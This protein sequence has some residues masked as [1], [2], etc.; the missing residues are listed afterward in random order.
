MGEAPF[1]LSRGKCISW[2]LFKL[3]EFYLHLKS[4]VCH[5][6]SKGSQIRLNGHIDCSW[7]NHKYCLPHSVEMAQWPLTAP[8]YYN[9]FSLPFPHYPRSIDLFFLQEIKLVCFI[10]LFFLTCARSQWPKF[11]IL[12]VLNG[13][14]WNHLCN[15]CCIIYMTYIIYIIIILLDYFNTESSARN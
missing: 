7:F 11:K 5:Q 9:I 4:G 13:V 1:R 12:T 3:L 15:T 14:K 6:A 8:R 2:A 10:V